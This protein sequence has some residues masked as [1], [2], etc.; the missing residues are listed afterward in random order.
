TGAHAIAL[1]RVPLEDPGNPAF[2]LIFDVQNAAGILLAPG[3]AMGAVMT[4]VHRRRVAR[5]VASLGAAPAP[6]SLESALARALGDPEL[7]V[8]YWVPDVQRYVDAQGGPVG[9]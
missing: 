4:V 3:L 9:S 8:A 5:I 6:G 2:Q 7:R 1:S